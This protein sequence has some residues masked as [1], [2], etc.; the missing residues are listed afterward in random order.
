MISC[1]V[2]HR[3]IIVN[4]LCSPSPPDGAGYLVTIRTEPRQAS[5]GAAQLETA[6][7]ELRPT[8]ASTR[9]P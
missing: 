5:D 9:F 7:T 2:D 6:Q 4:E 3:C 8:G 1:K